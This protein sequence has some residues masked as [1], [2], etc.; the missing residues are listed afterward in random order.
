MKLR[1]TSRAHRDIENIATYIGEEQHN[2]NV[3]KKVLKRIES[4]L[5]H[6][7]SFPYMGSASAK[8]NTRELTITGLPFCIVYRIAAD[9]VEVITV[10]HESQNPSKKL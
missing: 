9:A 8:P 6:I 4:V 5:D 7:C 3:A 1:L 10:F 2:P